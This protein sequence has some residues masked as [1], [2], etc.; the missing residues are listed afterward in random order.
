[1]RSAALRTILAAAATALAVAGCT[2]DSQAPAHAGAPAP[3]AAAPATTPTANERLLVAAAFYPIAEAVGRVGG[4]RVRVVNLTPPGAGPHDLELTPPQVE[5]VTGARAV[6]YLSGGLQP[7]V[8]KL[9]AGLT[10]VRAV[11]VLEGLDL[12]PVGEQLAGTRGE[13]DG[14]VLEGGGD[15][16]VWVDPVG[17]RGIAGKARDVL[18]ELDPAGAAEFARNLDGYLAELDALNSEFQTALTTCRSRVVVTSHR[19]FEYL[20]RRYGLIQIP[21]AGLSPEAEPDPRSLSAIA[22]AAKRE[23]VRTVFFEEQV[24][25]DFAETVA[26]EIGAGTSALDPVETI[27]ADDLAAGHT[28]GTVMRDNLG[29]LRAGLGCT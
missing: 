17:Q 18:A 22:A 26:R 8:A 14:E 19:A 23:G 5:E 9:V 20:A 16:H 15:P 10:G 3:A 28:Y 4:D 24:P 11:D 21:I 6:F 7:A 1:M 29:A 27:T 25:R 13:V 12:L 2:S